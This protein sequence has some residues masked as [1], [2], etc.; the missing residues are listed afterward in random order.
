M[1]KSMC[2]GDMVYL[3][4][5]LYILYFYI[6]IYL[7]SLYTLVIETG[8]QKFVFLEIQIYDQGWPKVG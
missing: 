5:Y 8:K 6:M 4:L 1:S 2:T 3:Y 7:W